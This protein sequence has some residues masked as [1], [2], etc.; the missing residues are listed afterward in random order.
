MIAARFA[1][2]ALLRLDHKNSKRKK[3]RTSSRFL[4]CVC[5]ASCV[6]VTQ[7]LPNLPHQT[8]LLRVHLL[9]TVK[10]KEFRTS[11]LGPFLQENRL[12]NLKRIC[13]NRDISIPKSYFRNFSRPFEGPKNSRITFSAT[14]TT[15]I[16]ST[17]L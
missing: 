14:C 4:I 1:K 3:E 5:L 13:R 8:Y 17:S 15:Y 12:K 2:Q 9:H 16:N 10:P 6:F 11:Q 7:I